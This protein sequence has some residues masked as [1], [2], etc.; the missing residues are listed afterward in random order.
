MNK[1]ILSLLSLF[2]AFNSFAGKDFEGFIKYKMNFTAKVS[3]VN[4][5]DLEKELGTSVYAHYKEGFY[6]EISNSS[7]MSLQ[8]YRHDSAALFFKNHVTDTVFMKVATNDEPIEDFSYAIEENADTIL[9]NVC[10]KL[11]VTDKHGTKSFYYSSNY[12]IDPKH[13]ETF[14]NANKNQIVKLMK[15]IYLRL[16]MSYQLF[17]VDI[18]ATEIKPMKLEDEMFEIPEGAKIQRIQK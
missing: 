3:G 6:K 4:I 7:W 11:T 9:G 10:N 2:I 14:T 12:P 13:Y 1:L 18:E 15:A 16:T 17:T 5:E 8:L